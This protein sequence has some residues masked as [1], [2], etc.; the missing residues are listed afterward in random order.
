M[1]KLFVLYGSLMV[2]LFVAAC[3]E[4]DGRESTMTGSLASPLGVDGGVDAGD[5][6]V[7]GGETTSD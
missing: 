7:D 3:S 1:S 5:G 2:A 4:N 6:G